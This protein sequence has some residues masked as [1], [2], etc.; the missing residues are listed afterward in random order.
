M[1]PVITSLSSCMTC[2]ETLHIKLYVTASFFQLKYQYNCIC[3]QQKTA[4]WGRSAIVSIVKIPVTYCVYLPFS[5]GDLPWRS[6]EIQV[7]AFIGCR[8]GFWRTEVAQCCMTLSCCKTKIVHFLFPFCF[9]D[10]IWQF[11]LTINAIIAWLWGL[12]SF[13]MAGPRF[14]VTLRKIGEILVI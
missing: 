8:P 2:L 6:L 11:V 14:H 10:L 4:V 7:P 9:F 12:F 1:V 13:W 5:V 3:F